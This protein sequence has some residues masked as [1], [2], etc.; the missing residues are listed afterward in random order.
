MFR[1]TIR[2]VLWLTVVVALAI[3]VA[4]DRR[5][6]AAATGRVRDLE[7]FVELVRAEN[8]N[9][10]KSD[11]ELQAEFEDLEDAIRRKGIVVQW[12]KDPSGQKFRIPKLR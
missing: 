5:S 3:V 2:D 6:L 4:L 8:A 11:R 12:E 1:F 7:G 10:A 9:W